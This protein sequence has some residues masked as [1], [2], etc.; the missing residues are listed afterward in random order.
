MGES[1]QLAPHTGTGAG[2]SSG[3]TVTSAGKAQANTAGVA[4]AGTLTTGKTAGTAMVTGKP[5]HSSSKPAASLT[6]SGKKRPTLP[7]VQKT[8]AGKQVRLLR[9]LALIVVA[10]YLCGLTGAKYYINSI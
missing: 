7:A 2:G 10:K 1:S 8:V 5:A 6:L 9:G 4:T 3:S